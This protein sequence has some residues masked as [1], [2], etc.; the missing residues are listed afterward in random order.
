MGYI[1]L[2]SPSRVVLLLLLRSIFREGC[3]LLNCPVTIKAVRELQRTLFIEMVACAPS[4]PK[5]N[6]PQTLNT[7]LHHEVNRRI[8]ILMSLSMLNSCAGLPVLG[9]RDVLNSELPRSCP[10]NVTLDTQNVLP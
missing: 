10:S 1:S 5:L 8:N 9:A 4:V 3:S 7:L 2:I 6:S